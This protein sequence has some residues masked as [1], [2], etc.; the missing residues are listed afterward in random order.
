MSSPASSDQWFSYGE[1]LLNRPFHKVFTQFDAGVG[2]KIEVHKCSY[3]FP[4]RNMSNFESL[5]VYPSKSDDFPKK[6]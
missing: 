5:T 4:N 3:I 6:S 1:S 2:A